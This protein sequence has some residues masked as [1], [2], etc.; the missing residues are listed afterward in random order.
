MGVGIVIT[1]HLAALLLCAAGSSP[2]TTA[3]PA[4][5]AGCCRNIAASNSLQIRNAPAV[6][7]KALAQ[8]QNLAEL[9]PLSF[10]D[11]RSQPVWQPSSSTEPR[12]RSTEGASLSRA[13]SSALSLLPIRLNPCSAD[14]PYLFTP[15]ASTAPLC[16]VGRAGWH[17]CCVLGKWYTMTR[18]FFM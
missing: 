8:W 6:G 15:V 12:L 18:S 13:H 7:G 17:G 11:Q 5:T 16:Y 1:R 10:E 4:G 3:S 14:L 2:L 9:D